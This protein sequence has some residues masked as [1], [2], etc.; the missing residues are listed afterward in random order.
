LGKLRCTCQYCGNEWETTAFL[1]E[2]PKC[3]KCT[4]T[5]SIKVRKEAGKSNVFG[6]EEDEK[7]KVSVTYEYVD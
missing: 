4:E 1:R 2:K 3:P 7:P 6:Y 5:Q